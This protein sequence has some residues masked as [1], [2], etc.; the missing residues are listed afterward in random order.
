MANLSITLECNRQCSYCFARTVPVRENKMRRETF[1][2][3]LA[4]LGRSGIPEVRLLGG[5]PSLHPDF[6]WFVER[7]IERRFKVVIFSNGVFTSRIA[8]TLERFQSKDLQLIINVNRPGSQSVKESQSQAGAWRRL[9]G[10]CMLGF[11]IHRPN[12]DL[13]FLLDLTEKHKLRRSIRL[14]LAHP[15]LDGTNDYLSPKHYA[16]VGKRIHEFH[17][18]AR[19]RNIHIEFDCGFVP[20]MFPAEFLTTLSAHAGAFVSG[21]GPIPDIMPDGT[22]THCYPLASMSRSSL[23]TGERSA[24]LK[25]KLE[26]SLQLY[27]RLGIYQECLQCPLKKGGMCSGGCLSAALQRLRS[28]PKGV[29]LSLVTART[30]R[31]GLSHADVEHSNVF[32]GKRV[33]R[34]D[35]PV[36]T[37]FVIPYIDQPPE[38][39]HEVNE[40]FGS[41]IKSVYFPLPETTLGSG[42][43]PQ[44]HQYLD[45]FLSMS[46]FCFSVLINPVIL[47]RPVREVVPPLMDTLKRVNEKYGLTDVTVTNATLALAIKENIPSLQ[48]VASTLMDIANTNQLL[49]VENAF[50]VIVPSSRIMR[51][52]RALKDLKRAFHGKIRLIVNEGCLPGCP[53]RVQHFF[54]MAN[55]AIT[56]PDSLCKD[57]LERR[58][59]MRLTGAWVLPQHLPCYEGIYDE[60]KLAGRVTLNDPA[61][62]RSVLAAYI[63]RQSLLPNRIGGGPASVLEPIEIDEEFYTTT[64]H[65]N[66]QCDRCSVCPTYYQESLKRAATRKLF[67]NDPDLDRVAHHSGR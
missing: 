61:K 42:R 50:D 66:R 26:H 45:K 64:L 62:Y 44:P 37:R 6:L 10:L 40:E 22:A 49:M 63:K 29:G 51:D 9:A 27:R 18:R 8:A 11:N 28:T 31:S 36:Q 3:T 60:L 48:T 25:R 21:C 47:K 14:G 15:C 4:F 30:V 1:L 19:G 12:P 46:S 65:C 20:C 5:E 67:E 16:Q 23:E 32:R 7:S 58:P 54:E 43:P 56:F 17:D 33:E 39:W 55:N 57:L 13:D 34:A 41:H 24:G 35:H 2:D 52:H 38:F 59:W 53:F